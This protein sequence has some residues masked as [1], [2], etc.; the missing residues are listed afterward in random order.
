M[1]ITYVF[2]GN[3]SQVNVALPLPSQ[4]IGMLGKPISEEHC[5]DDNGRGEPAEAFR[6]PDG[7]PV[8][9]RRSGQKGQHVD[10]CVGNWGHFMALGY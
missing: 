9:R 2:S 1:L 8:H 10:N 4:T 6:V 7:E 5:L 3:L